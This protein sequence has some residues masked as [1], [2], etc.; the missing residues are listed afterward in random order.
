MQNNQT[1]ITLASN[2]NILNSNKNNTKTNI[3]RGFH[4]YQKKLQTKTDI[5][6]KPEIRAT[7]SIFSTSIKNWQLVSE[8]K[9]LIVKEKSAVNNYYPPSC[10]G[11]DIAYCKTENA[12]YIYGGISCSSSFNQGIRQYFY[13][14]SD[15]RWSE[16]KHESL[17]NP[18]PRYGHTLTPY[19]K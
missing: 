13:K 10:S 1:L 4:S 11:Y 12:I 2:Q 18:I 15:S 7:Q 17:Y 8:Q 5:M 6:K 3:E 19:Q 14:Y 9:R 16:V